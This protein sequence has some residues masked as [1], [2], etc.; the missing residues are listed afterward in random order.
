MTDPTTLTDEELAGAIKDSDFDAFKV[1]YYR[2][3][4]RLCHFVW[5][6]TSRAELA[7]DVVQEIFTR[8]WQN[9]NRYTIRKSFKAY[10]YRM[11]N[12]LIIDLHRKRKHETDYLSQFES[13]QNL[14]RNDHI[15]LS[16]DVE[17]AVNKLPEKLRSVFILSRFEDLKYTEIARVCGISIKAVESRI[18]RA[19]RILREDLS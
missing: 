8:L 17:S 15:D 6:R 3:Y 7:E 18:G 13:K 5:A 4:E 16:I 1:L 9:R 10:L 11:A 19:L 2:Y 12:N 14:A